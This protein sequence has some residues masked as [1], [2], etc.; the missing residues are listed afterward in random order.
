M[1]ESAVAV[2]GRTSNKKRCKETPWR[3]DTVKESER[4]KKKAFRVWF[5]ERNDDAIENY[6]ETIKRE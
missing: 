1:V 2:C 3:N 6:K 5:Q 4:R